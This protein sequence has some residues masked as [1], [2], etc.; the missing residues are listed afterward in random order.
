MY[1][2]LA[3]DVD[4]TLLDPQG[5]IRP[6]VKQ[7]VRMATRAGCL[8]TL[9]TGR[10]LLSAHRIAEELEI[11]V[12]LILFTGSLIYDTAAEKALLHQ[13]LSRAF[14]QQAVAA[15]REINLCPIVL[16]SPLRGEHIY[17]GPPNEDNHYTRSYAGGKTR[18]EMIRRCS[19]E[20]LVNVPDGL[21][22]SVAGPENL[23]A[24]L[25]EKITA[26][27]ECSIFGYPLRQSDLP[28]LHGYDLIQPGVSKGNALLW[29]AKHF[30]IDQSQTIAIGDSPNDLEMLKAAGLGIAM[31]NAVPEVKAQ[32]G[33]VVAP[34]WQDGVAEAIEYYVL[35]RL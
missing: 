18:V 20:E 26:R 5:Q 31:G 12:P 30:G 14:M 28:D 25:Q 27:L 15:V 21:T 6:R 24:Y 16:Q 22:F 9:A 7:A 3:I 29:L 19:Y 32:A 8:V 10:R 35:R 33:T 4:G 13:T 17:L 1:K 11:N 23:L 34:N 2:L